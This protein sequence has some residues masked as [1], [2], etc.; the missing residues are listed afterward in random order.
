MPLKKF[1]LCK[2]SNVAFKH[3]QEILPKNGY[4]IVVLDRLHQVLYVKKNGL[5]FSKFLSIKIE[6]VVTDI[7][8]ETYGFSSIFFKLQHKYLSKVA[9]DLENVLL[10]SQISQM[11]R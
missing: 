4:R 11:N 1:K 8:F 7:S 6:L 9:N 3:L 10:T 2:P 5:L